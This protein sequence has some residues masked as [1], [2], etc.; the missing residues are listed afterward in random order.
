LTTARWLTALRQTEPNLF[1]ASGRE[2]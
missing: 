2:H 1:T